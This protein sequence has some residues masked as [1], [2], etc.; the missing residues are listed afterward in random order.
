MQRYQKSRYK[1]F[2]S[3]WES[4]ERTE[5][6]LDKL[7]SRLLAEEMRH[8]STEKEEEVA[9]KAEASKTGNKICRK[10]NKVGHIARY[11]KFD[12][13]P[14]NNKDIKCFK[15]DRMSHIARYYTK[16]VKDEVVKFARKTITKKKIVISGK[17]EQLKIVIRK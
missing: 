2:R 17:D 16:N 4:T 3:A 15:C 10:C 13:R 1:Y 7:T 6:T 12:A 14:S 5:K 9:F 11:C 8:T